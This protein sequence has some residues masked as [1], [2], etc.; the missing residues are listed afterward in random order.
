VIAVALARRLQEAGLVWRP[1]SGDRFVIADREMDDTVF[2]VSEMVV[3]PETLAAGGLLKFNGT[4]EWAL[5]SLDQ[6]AALWLPREDQ[7]REALGAAFVRL[8]RTDLGWAVV[9]SSSGAEV[10]TEHPDTEDAYA[11]ALLAHLGGT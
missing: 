9:T 2:V 4:T 1:A 8:E 7:L 10:R 11:A 3:E 6:D 5:D